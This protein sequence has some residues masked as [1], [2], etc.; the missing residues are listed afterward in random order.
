VASASEEEFRRYLLRP[1]LAAAAD[2]GRALAASGSVASA[3]PAAPG[4]VPET[5]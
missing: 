5:A 2:I 1:V 3:P 4:A